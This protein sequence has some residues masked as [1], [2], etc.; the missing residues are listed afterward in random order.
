MLVLNSSSIIL[1]LFVVWPLKIKRHVIKNT[2]WW[3]LL[4][5]LHKKF[6]GLQYIV[7][8]LNTQD[9]YFVKLTK[10]PLPKL[11]SSKEIST[12]KSQNYLKKERFYALSIT[13]GKKIM[14][15]CS[16]LSHEINQGFSFCIIMVF[17][18]S[19][20]LTNKEGLLRCLSNWAE[21]CL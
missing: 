17:T 21:Q 13:H 1:I 12:F 3:K 4:R 11:R 6:S 2:F 15:K 10:L 5:N 19:V 7:L 20:S 14:L 8:N 18:D 16:I 9:C